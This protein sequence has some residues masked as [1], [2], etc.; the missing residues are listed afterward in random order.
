MNM[1]ED[2][3]PPLHVFVNS[4]LFP[5]QVPSH[6]DLATTTSSSFTLYIIQKSGIYTKLNIMNI[7]KNHGIGSLNLSKN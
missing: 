3:V 2:G 6:L 1:K 7:D 4:V 5:N